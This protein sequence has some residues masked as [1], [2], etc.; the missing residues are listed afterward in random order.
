MYEAMTTSPLD[1]DIELLESLDALAA[2]P[3]DGPGQ[4]AW[5]NFSQGAQ[6]TVQAVSDGY[7]GN[8]SGAATHGIQAVEHFG[9]AGYNAYQWYN[10]GH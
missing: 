9:T 5:S 2:T 7:N 10:G 4:Q 1:L 8:W 6:H 3:M